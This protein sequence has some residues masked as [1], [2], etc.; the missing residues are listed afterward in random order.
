MEKLFA[1]QERVINEKMDEMMTMIKNVEEKVGEMRKD[2]EVIQGDSAALRK[3]LE[4]LK[5]TVECERQYA[6]SR[7]IIISGIPFKKNED[8]AQSITTL[9]G[10][11]EIDIRTQDIST[12]RLPSKNENHSPAIL[13]LN[14]R[15]IRDR[16][17]K[18][19]R[20]RKPDTGLINP[21]LPKKA[22]YFND[23]LTPYFNTLMMKVKEISK[24]KNYKYVWM[25]GDRI[26]VRKDELSKGIRII[27]LEDLDKMI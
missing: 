9:L 27:K 21:D 19:A 4:D 3:E 17:I 11:M 18:A 2:I 14:S 26:M 13:Q 6:R 16:I 24:K 1:K 20:K 8:L 5:I 23:H 10:K 22:I 7:N 25:N 15:A 12:H